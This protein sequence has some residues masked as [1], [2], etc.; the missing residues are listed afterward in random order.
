MAHKRKNFTDIQ[1]AQI[2]VRDRATCCFSGANLWLLDS[3]LRPGIETDW[4]D[5]VL[6]SARGGGNDIDNGVCASRTYNSLKRHNTDDNFYLFKNGLPTVGFS[7]RRRALSKT[8]SGRGC[9]GSFS[10][11]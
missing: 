10:Q 8:A 7:Q 1:K 3:P 2:F 9:A 6:P 11:K 4:V 5:H